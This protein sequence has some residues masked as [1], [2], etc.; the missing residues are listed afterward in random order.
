MTANTA[1]AEPR[2]DANVSTSGSELPR[3]KLPIRTENSTFRSGEE[4]N[5]NGA[6]IHV[7]SGYRD[8]MTRLQFTVC[9]KQR[10]IPTQL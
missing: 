4:A 10:P 5:E 9:Y 8:H 2:A 3:E 7:S 1:V 6:T